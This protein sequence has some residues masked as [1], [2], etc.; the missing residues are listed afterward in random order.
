MQLE[1]DIKVLASVR[2]NSRPA[3]K[4]WEEGGVLHWYGPLPFAGESLLSQSHSLP[5]NNKAHTAVHTLCMRNEPMVMKPQPG[6]TAVAAAEEPKSTQRVASC[7]G[8]RWLLGGWGAF[9]RVHVLLGLLCCCNCIVLLCFSW[10]LNHYL[11]PYSF[12]Q[13]RY[14]FRSVDPTCHVQ[15]IDAVTCS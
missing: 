2:P 7:Y 10:H 6:S 9:A 14:N 5:A 11:K 8:G 15:C 3:R 12:T 1:G 4:A 13:S